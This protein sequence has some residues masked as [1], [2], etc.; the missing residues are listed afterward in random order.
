MRLNATRTVETPLTL[1]GAAAAKRDA[2]VMR[3]LSR[4]P[5]A[6]AAEYW[7][8]LGATLDRRNLS[9]RLRMSER[10]VHYYPS[11]AVIVRRTVFLAF[12]GQTAA[13]RK[14][15]ARA[16]YTFPKRC[17]ETTGILAQALAA[18][19]GA[20]EPLLALAR[21]SYAGTCM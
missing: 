9:E 20:I 7:T 3:S 2:D 17:T 10:A 1:A 12:D 11:N 21:H 13:A 5:L 6:P 16:M 8:V 18:D 19:P 4:G 14:L 15:L